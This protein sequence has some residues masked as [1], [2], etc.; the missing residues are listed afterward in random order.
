MALRNQLVTQVLPLGG[1]KYKERTPKQVRCHASVLFHSPLFYSLPFH[2]MLLYLVTRHSS[3]C[4]PILFELGTF[5]SML[6][7]F[8]LFH[9]ISSHSITFH[10]ILQLCRISSC[11]MQG[12][13]LDVTKAV[14]VC[15]CVCV[16]TCFEG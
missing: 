6:F 5:Y 7:W 16:H 3:L 4:G 8:I 12:I 14:C 2:S 11:L 15:V 10:S 9:L 13:L 1:H